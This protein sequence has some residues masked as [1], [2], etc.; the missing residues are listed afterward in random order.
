MGN[1]SNKHDD[2]EKYASIWKQSEINRKP[3]F[4]PVFSLRTL[5]FS[6]FDVLLVCGLYETSRTKNEVN[7]HS[8]L[9]FLFPRKCYLQLI[10]SDYLPDCV[11]DGY[12]MY[13]YLS[14]L[15]FNSNQM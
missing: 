4:S 11:L 13:A 6:D 12:I 1:R 7:N 3:P 10:K 9:C 5:F 15:H 14:T 8:W 2:G